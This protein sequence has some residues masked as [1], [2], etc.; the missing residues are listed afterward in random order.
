MAGRLPRAV[1]RWTQRVLAV[2]LLA[3]DTEVSRL[4][5]LVAFSK[6]VRIYPMR[7]DAEQAVNAEA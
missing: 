1:A 4:L 5:D 3:P 2:N 7:E 6:V